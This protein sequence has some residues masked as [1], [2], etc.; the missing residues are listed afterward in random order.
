MKRRF[1]L[2]IVSCIL[3]FSLTACNAE[4]YKNAMA[5]YDSGAYEEALKAFEALG[6]YENSSEMVKECKYQIAV[7]F[8]KS[9]R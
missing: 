3:M 6:D 5:Q 8:L 1:V 9:L 4:D 2:F 7:S